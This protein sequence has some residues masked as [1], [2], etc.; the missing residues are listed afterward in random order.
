MI[1][2]VILSL[3]LLISASQGKDKYD[4]HHLGMG[5]GRAND[6]S[7]SDE[8]YG[9]PGTALRCDD[10]CI[11]EDDQWN[12]PCKSRK[13]G[14]ERMFCVRWKLPFYC[15]A[16]NTCLSALDQCDGACATYDEKVNPYSDFPESYPCGDKCIDNED[17][18][19]KKVCD[20][21]CVEKSQVCDGI[22]EEVERKIYCSGMELDCETCSSSYSFKCANNS[23][24][25]FDF[26]VCDGDND[27][28]DGSDEENCCGLRMNK[29]CTSCNSKDYMM[30][31]SRIQC[32]HE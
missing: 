21:Q 2:S 28:P 32:F 25:L 4:K 19:S 17:A 8:N 6:W 23:K 20:G 1:G 5:M 27:C 18:A 9:C 24:C 14:E 31:E 26:E 13:Q 3:I 15:P 22:E 16:Q 29:N 7:D 11:F 12:K 10:K 30:C